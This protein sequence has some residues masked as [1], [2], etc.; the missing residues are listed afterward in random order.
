VIRSPHEAPGTTPAYQG[1]ASVAETKRTFIAIELDEAVR[2]RFRELQRLLRPAE[3][4][5][6]WVKPE[7]AHLT[8][9]FLGEATADQIGAMSAALDEIA[10]ATAAFEVGFGGLGV[11]P[12]E[13]RP[14]VL[15]VGITT[16]TEQVRTLAAAI[17]ERAAR[18]GFA[19]ERRPFSGHLTLGRFRSPSGWDGLRKLVEA[20]GDFDAGRIAVRHLHLIHSLLSPEGPKYTP[21][22]TAQLAISQ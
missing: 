8:L 17:D 2:A 9:K 12:N 19:R 5:V 22:H 11:F 18:A 20:N 1:P 7:R 3:A 16:G 4:D 10:P 15:W 21:L 14:R 13:H 6:R